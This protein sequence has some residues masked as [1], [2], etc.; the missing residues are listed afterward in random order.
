MHFLVGIRGFGYLSQLA[1]DVCLNEVCVLGQ[2][3]TILFTS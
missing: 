2:D 1:K 3:L